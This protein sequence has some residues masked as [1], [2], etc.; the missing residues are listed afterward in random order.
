M[1]C[2]CRCDDMI[3][4]VDLCG[5]I[6]DFHGQNLA[7]SGALIT[8]NSSRSPVPGVEPRPTSVTNIGSPSPGIARLTCLTRSC[9]NPMSCNAALF[10]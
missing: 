8:V 5:E 4:M 2:L 3:L 10:I 1:F 7:G 6:P 9:H